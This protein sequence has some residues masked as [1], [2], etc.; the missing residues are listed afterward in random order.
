ML[1]LCKI[2][3]LFVNTLTAD[4]KYSLVNRGNLKEP[5]QI[6]LNQKDKTFSQFF[7]SFQKSALNFE[8]FQKKMT[9]IAD[10][11]PILPSPKKVIRKI[12]GKSNSECPSTNNMGNIHKHCCNVDDGTFPIFIDHFK[13]NSVGKSL[14]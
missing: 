12:S 13:Y 10:V 9:L 11:F 14:R 7:C 8:H 6:L 3:R 2:L 5:I 4:D 1:V